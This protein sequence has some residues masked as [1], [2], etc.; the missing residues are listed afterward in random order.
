MVPRAYSLCIESGI[1][2]EIVIPKI[3]TKSCASCAIASEEMDKLW[4]SFK[5]DLT[6]YE[7]SQRSDDSDNDIDENY[8]SVYLSIIESQLSTN[9]SQFFYHIRSIYRIYKTT[10][11]PEIKS[12][13]KKLTSKYPYL[14]FLISPKSVNNFQD[15][16]AKWLTFL[17]EEELIHISKNKEL[18]SRI[19]QLIKESP[20]KK[21]LFDILVTYFNN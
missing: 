11:S 8:D 21:W 1:N 4:E 19:I 16:S 10:S 5:N 17:W 14:H 7:L 20:H 15:F 3:V 12:Q 2:P 13:I 18:K 6:F 9:H